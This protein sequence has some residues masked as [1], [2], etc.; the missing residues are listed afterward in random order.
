MPTYQLKFHECDGSVSDAGTL[1]DAADLASA[2]DAAIMRAREIMAAE[3]MR[4]RLCLSCWIVI[5]DERG[6]NQDTLQFGET[7]AFNPTPACVHES[8]AEARNTS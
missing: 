5:S 6:D 7:I 8:E 2:R 4:G 3:I 1:V